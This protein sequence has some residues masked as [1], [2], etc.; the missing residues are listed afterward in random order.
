MQGYRS[1]E[2]KNYRD[3][4]IHL[5]GGA[6]AR[7]H[8]SM[9]EGVILQVHHK[10]YI[11]GRKSWEYP[12]DLC[13]ALC[14]ACHAE[15]HGKIPPRFGWEYFGD[16]DLEDLIGSCE[17]CGTAIR[18]KFLIQHQKWGALE[19]GTICCDNLTCTQV[20]S[21]H[22]E[23]TRR[24]NDRKKRF[25]S[26]SRWIIGNAG[27]PVIKQKE[28]LVSVVPFGH[29]WRLKIN[30]EIGKFDFNSVLEAKVKSFELIECGKF[31]EYFA[32]RRR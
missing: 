7:C 21:D 25:V 5:D 16:D 19:V 29:C 14:R 31:K 12:Y 1:A 8:R 32:K 23:S 22:V 6:C 27:N 20:A 10:R 30:G 28:F 4:V 13:E 9:A 17:Y 2:W 15:E 18:Y 11:P 3:E 24:F 26:S